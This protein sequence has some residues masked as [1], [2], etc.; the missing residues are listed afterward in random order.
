MVHTVRYCSCSRAQQIVC[1]PVCTVLSR[2]QPFDWCSCVQVEASSRRRAH[3]HDNGHLL[4]RAAQS[5]ATVPS[6]IR[7]YS[8][9]I[10]P[11]HSPT[12]GFTTL[13]GCLPGSTPMPKPPEMRG[14]TASHI[15][16]AS[17]AAW[18]AACQRLRPTRLSPLAVNQQSLAEAAV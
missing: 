5:S 4:K 18:I 11:K 9:R 15:I 10:H 8:R 16:R 7:P 3:L 1:L 13:L 14:G 2:Q 17:L 12:N 6:C